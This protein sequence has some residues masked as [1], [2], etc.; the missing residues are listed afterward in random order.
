MVNLVTLFKP[1]QYCDRIFLGGL[2]DQYLLKAA[3]QRCVFLDILTI[4]IERCSTNTVQFASR[5]RW[6]QHVTR[7]HCTLGLACPNHR[8]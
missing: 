8:M 7:I 5:E 1:S 3:L 6:L 4:F 2:I